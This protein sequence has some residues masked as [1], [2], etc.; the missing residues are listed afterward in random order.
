MRQEVFE[1]HALLEAAKVPGPYVLVGQSIGG[2]LVRQYA[3]QYGGDVAGVVLVDPTHEDDVNYNLR[4]GRWVRLRDLATGRPIPKP[5]REGK[6]STRY[7]PDEDYLAEELQQIFL[8]R[9]DKPT[10]LGERPLIVLGAGKRSQ[11]PGTTEEFWKEHKRQRDERVRDL[12]RL[13]GNSKFILDPSSGHAIHADNP[14]LVARAI[15]EVLEA[16]REKATLKP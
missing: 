9:R 3:E 14:Q 7:D 15:E 8:S 1:L 16:A 10:P 12:A 6:A 4:A 2:L 5:R 13:S 11:P